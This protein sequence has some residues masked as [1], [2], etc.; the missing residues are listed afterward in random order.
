MHGKWTRE[1]FEIYHQENPKVYELFCYYSKIAASK[2]ERYSARGIF[3][4]LRWHTMVRE[5]EGEYKL[6][7]GWTPHY[8][9]KFMKEFPE[10]K[11]FFET[12]I[13]VHSYHT[14]ENETLLRAEQIIN[15]QNRKEDRARLGPD[16]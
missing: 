8:A 11:D 15:G 10:H 2:R 14:H 4:Q 3:H 9:R 1:N 13:R 6:D 16:S 7:A 5:K 12:R